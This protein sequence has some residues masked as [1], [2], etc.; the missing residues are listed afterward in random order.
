MTTAARAPSASSGP[1]SSARQTW[2][3]YTEA[4]FSRALDRRTSDAVAVKHYN[5]LK[6]ELERRGIEVTPY[7]I[8]LAWNGGIGAVVARNPSAAAGLRVARGEPRRGASRAASWPT[9]R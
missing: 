4:P 1:T 6:A 2:K 5:W 8:A 3:M 9:R 7:R